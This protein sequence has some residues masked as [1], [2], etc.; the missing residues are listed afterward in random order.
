MQKKRMV[1]R[2]EGAHGG[3][4]VVGLSLV[5]GTGKPRLAVLDR[6]SAGVR[7]RVALAQQEGWGVTVVRGREPK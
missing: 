3:R 5:F 1:G 6:P 7:G 2:G 4:N